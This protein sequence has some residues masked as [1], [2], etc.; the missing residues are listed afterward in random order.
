MLPDPIKWTATTLGVDEDRYDEARSNY[1]E[2]RPVGGPPPGPVVGPAGVGI[3][4]STLGKLA[5]GGAILGFEAGEDVSANPELR[6][7]IDDTLAGDT[8]PTG[9]DPDG[10][11]EN[12]LVTLASILST[13]QENGQAIIA[14]VVALVVVYTVGQLITINVGDSTS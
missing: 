9:T 7:D 11:P 5:Q 3:A 12:P 1:Q 4:S 14:G 10:S 8:D 6:E 13:M 2:N